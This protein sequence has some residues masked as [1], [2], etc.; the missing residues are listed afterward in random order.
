[1]GLPKDLVWK[2]EQWQSLYDEYGL[3]WYR[4]D[5]DEFLK[6]L[7]TA[8]DEQKLE[9]AKALKAHFKGEA[10]IE[11]YVESEDDIK[12]IK[13]YCVMA[14]Y[15]ALWDEEDV[16]ICFQNIE[17][18]CNISLQSNEAKQLEKDL[19]KWA[20]EHIDLEWKNGCYTPVT[21]EAIIER[22]R[23]LTERLKKIAKQLEKDLD[24]WAKEHID[25]EWKNG[26]YTPVTD[27]A[28]IERGRILTERLKKILPNYCVVE[29]IE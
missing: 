25:L 9:L 24:K 20:K 14:D 11:T 12:E 17:E 13:Y 28:I 15:D 19:D 23:I 22:G 18:D 10:Y 8:F 27:E 21:D 3:Y 16:G 4:D 1:M 26:C 29:Y 6:K 2:F 5:A 7:R